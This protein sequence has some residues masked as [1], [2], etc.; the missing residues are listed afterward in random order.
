MTTAAIR[1]P[2]AGAMSSTDDPPVNMAQKPPINMT[3]TG[4]TNGH[5][6]DD[7]PR[8]HAHGYVVAEQSI[9]PDVVRTELEAD[10]DTNKRRHG[11]DHGGAR[12]H[13]W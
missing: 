4:R 12:P 2:G 10:P 1:P 13:E 6:R 5:K 7:E 11:N 8:A 9:G 3:S